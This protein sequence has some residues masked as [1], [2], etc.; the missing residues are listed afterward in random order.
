MFILLISRGV[1]TKRDPQWGCFERDQA[2]ALRALGHKVV[3]VSV[4]TRIR[5]FYRKFGIKRTNLDGIDYFDCFILPSIIT[6][7]L[8]GLRNS[9]YIRYLQLSVYSP[10]LRFHGA[11]GP[12]YKREPW[13][14]DVKT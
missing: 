7:V 10:I 4:D 9:V 5:L 13:L 8:L 11:R 12:Y 2:N 14:W 1:P 3:V 6:R